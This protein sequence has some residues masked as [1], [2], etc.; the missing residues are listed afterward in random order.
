MNMNIKGMFR[1][2]YRT[3]I[4]GLR[5]IAAIPVLLFHAGLSEHLTNEGSILMIEKIFETK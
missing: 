2:Q 3:E 5:A 4:D 1:M